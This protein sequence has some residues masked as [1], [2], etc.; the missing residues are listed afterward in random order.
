MLKSLSSTQF[1]FSMGLFFSLAFMALG[2]S[3][4]ASLG[5]GVLGGYSIACLVKWWQIDEKNN[6]PEPSKMEVFTDNLS[7]MLTQSKSFQSKSKS[8]KT[9]TRATTLLG[10][11]V[12]RNKS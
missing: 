4:M 3:L 9:P 11:I 6:A 12:K 1:G 2:D 5:F 10:W 7:E 8:S